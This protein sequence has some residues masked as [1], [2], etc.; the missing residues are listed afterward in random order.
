MPHK[1]KI[2]T[3]ILFLRFSFFLFSMAATQSYASYLTIDGHAQLKASSNGQNI[4]LSGSYEIENHGDES[5]RNV[6]PSIRLGS[7]SWAGEPKTI[8]QGGKETWPIDAT[9]PIDKLEFQEQDSCANQKLPSSGIFPLLVRRHYEDA[10]GARF[11]AAEVNRLAIGEL[12]GESLTVSRAPELDAVLHCG[13][14]GTDFD[15]NLEI[16]NAANKKYAV[17]VSYFTSNELEILSSARVYEIEPHNLVKGDVQLRNFS[18]LP[19]SSYA[20]FAVLQWQDRD[21]R[22]LISTSQVIE[23]KRPSHKNLF[24]LSGIATLLMA[25]IL[26]Y[27]IVFRK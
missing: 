25:V 13:G 5:A 10:N 21:F 2:S 22:N 1:S 24:I 14:N 9:L 17:S 20:V 4:I 7:F 16:R 3:V 12:Q 27:V 8:V 23:V 18:G 26:L 15:C 6:F 11:S 19:G